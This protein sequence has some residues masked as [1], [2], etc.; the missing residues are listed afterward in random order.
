MRDSSGKKVRA[1]LLGA[2][3]RSRGMSKGKFNKATK[4]GVSN[5]RKYKAR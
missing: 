3:L 1:K 5:G 4:L 2:E